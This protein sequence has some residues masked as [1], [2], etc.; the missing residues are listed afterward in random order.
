[1]G[2]HIAWQFTATHPNRVKKLILIDAAGYPNESKSTRLA[3]Q[4]AKIPLIK[5]MFTF[6]TPK[7]VARKSVENVYA[8]KSK[9]TTDLAMRYFELTL[10]AGNRQAFVDRLSVEN[11]PASYHLIPNISQPTLI[12]WGDQDLL[13]PIE[14]AKLFQKNIWTEN[15]PIELDKF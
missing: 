10:R 5:S 11:N 1:M 9:V 2:G 12:L 14:N 15:V 4:I 8:D 7:A 6:I 3:F 13:I